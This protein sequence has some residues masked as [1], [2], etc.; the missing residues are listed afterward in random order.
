[1]ASRPCGF[2]SRFEHIV[3]IRDALDSASDFFI[4]MIRFPNAKI[5]IGLDIVN[6]RQDGY[7][8]IVSVF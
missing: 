1:M 3:I 8:D 5:N 4:S 2:E 6:R 7:H